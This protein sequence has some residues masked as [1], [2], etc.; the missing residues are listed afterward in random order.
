MNSQ[1]YSPHIARRR[2]R[3]P[4]GQA[5]V[6]MLFFLAAFI[7]GPVSFFGYE[8]SL[9]NLAKLQLKAC[10]DSAALAAGCSQATN[11]NSNFATVQ[12]QAQD[13]AAWMFRQN[14]V[15][16]DSLSA[17]S[18]L[19]VNSPSVLNPTAHNAQIAFQWMDPATDSVVSAGNPLGKQIRVWGAYGFVPVFSKFAKL[20]GTFPVID[21]AN[22]GLPQLDVVL[23]FDLSGSMDDFTYVFLVRRARTS[24]ATATPVYTVVNA[25]GQNMSPLGN[26][27]QALYYASGCTAATGT[28]LNATWPQGLNQGQSPRYYG[29]NGSNHDAPP[30]DTAS[31]I[32]TKYTDLI[33]DVSYAFASVAAKD[34]YQWP[35]LNANNIGL[36]VEASRGNL[37]SAGD[38]S[39]AGLSVINTNQVSFGGTNYTCQAGW[40]NRYWSVANDWKYLNP[41]GAGAL[42][43]QNFFQIMNNDCDSHFGLVGYNSS[44]SEGS[45]TTDA[46]TRTDGDLNNAYGGGSNGYPW[47]NVGYTCCPY[48]CLDPGATSAAIKYTEV[49]SALTNVFNGSGAAT[50]GTQSSSINNQ[51]KPNGSTDIAGALRRALQQLMTSAESSAGPSPISG[52]LGRAR[53]N[54]TRAVVL[55][56]DGLPTDTS[57]GGN[58]TTDAL[59]MGSEARS[60][61]I[62]IYCIGL[63]MTP[64]LQ[65][66]QNAVL[67]DSTGIAG[68]S[69]PQAQY[70]QATDQASLITAFEA[71]ARSL[72]QLV[73]N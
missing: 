40:Y 50:S 2:G 16:G 52:G 9:Y 29:R 64:T 24:S 45:G 47:D 42:A 14:S 30:T 70:F 39:A 8:V 19:G 61:G 31:T 22:G 10:V 58:A 1:N 38:A 33:V 59:N 20:S 12:S 6:V 73:R 43:A 66:A 72:V 11:N 18:N 23:C 60:A 57:L 48:V 46:V 27:A 21:Y 71:V 62:P 7:I 36:A 15:L 37:E 69:A 54:S 5:V 53:T 25:G 49:N 56:T 17:A 3:T 41:I 51:V 32:G 68:L 4:S 67:N 65:S 34:L 35:T 28:S 13:T 63:C 55:F 26:G 44:N